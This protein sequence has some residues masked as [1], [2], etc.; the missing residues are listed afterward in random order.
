M[1]SSQRFEGYKIHPIDK[2]E[3]FVDKYQTVHKGNDTTGYD[4]ACSIRN[5]N[6]K[7]K[8]VSKDCEEC[9]KTFKYLSESADRKLGANEEN[10]YNM[11][12]IMVKQKTEKLVQT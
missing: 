7:T 6:L 2:P 4:E 12:S 8:L 10:G 5:D 11:D 3:S 1:T 9:A